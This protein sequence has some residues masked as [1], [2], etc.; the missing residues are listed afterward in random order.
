MIIGVV[1][2]PLAA[3]MLFRSL[4]HGLLSQTA[5]IQRFET[6][7]FLSWPVIGSTLLYVGFV[8]AFLSIHSPTPP[9]LSRTLLTLGGAALLAVATGMV[10]ERA[11][12]I[13]PAVLFHSIAA[14]SAFLTI[15]FTT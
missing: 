13:W 4:A 9:D 15:F 14:A 11:Q 7:W 3:E 6:R 8:W 5:K 10:R 12:S 2:L 1:G